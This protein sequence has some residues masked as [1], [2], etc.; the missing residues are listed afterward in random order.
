MKTVK[1]V[2]ESLEGGWFTN[3][4]KVREMQP[5]MIESEWF[6]ASGDIG[7][8]RILGLESPLKLLRVTEATA[9]KHGGNRW[10]VSW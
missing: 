4:K 1:E 8:L 9:K 3:N 5:R 2:L 10:K 7:R 6:N